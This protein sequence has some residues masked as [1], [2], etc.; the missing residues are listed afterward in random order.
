[1]EERER[2]ERGGDAAAAAA[3][4]TLKSSISFTSSLPDSCLVMMG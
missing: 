4:F 2:G 3:M 1:M